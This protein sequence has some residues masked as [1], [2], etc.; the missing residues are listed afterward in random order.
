MK[1]TKSIPVSLVIPTYNR[2][3]KLVRLL[4]SLDK[5]TPAPDEVI[6]I[7]DNSK[8]GTQRILKKWKT[9]ERGFKKKVILKEKNLGNFW[10]EI[11]G[12]G[13]LGSRGWDEAPPR[14]LREGSEK[15]ELSSDSKPC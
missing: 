13:K 3:Q 4:K 9:I 6:I 12:G 2:V 14:G 1:L 11:G 7:D 5:L 10:F 8:D 15:R